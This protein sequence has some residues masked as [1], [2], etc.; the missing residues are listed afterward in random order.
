VQR[1][2]HD[3]AAFDARLAG[4]LELYV[5]EATYKGPSIGKIVSAALAGAV[6]LSVSIAAR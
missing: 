5:S 1:T 2:P 3:Q 6:A 4:A